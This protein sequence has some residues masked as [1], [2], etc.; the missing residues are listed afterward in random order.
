MVLLFSCGSQLIKQ[1]PKRAKNET[2][3]KLTDKKGFIFHN[4]CKK[5]KKKQRECKITEYDLL[6]EWEFFRGSFILI[7]SKYVFP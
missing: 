3:Y 6:K 1:G 7:P 2:F 4:T 5:V